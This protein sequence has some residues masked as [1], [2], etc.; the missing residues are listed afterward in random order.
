M[1]GRLCGG[2][3]DPNGEKGDA[4]ELRALCYERVA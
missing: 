3:S 1:I 2:L 4:Q